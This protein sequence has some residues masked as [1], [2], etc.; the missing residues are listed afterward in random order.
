MAT[1]NCDEM[2]TITLA[3]SN[4]P[5]DCPNEWTEVYTWTATDNCENS[6]T[7]SLTVNYVDEVAP[8]FTSVPEDLFF[9]C[10]DDVPAADASMLSATDNCGD[11]VIE[12]IGDEMQGDECD[13]VISRTY[14]ATDE[15]GLFTDYV[16]TINVADTLNPTFDQAVENLT[17]ECDMVPEPAQI[18][19]SDNCDDQVSVVFNE[20]NEEGECANAYTLIRTWTATDD[21]GN[22]SVLTQIINVEDNTAPVFVD[23]PADATYNCDD[24]IPA[25]ED[26]IAVDNCSE[27][28][29][30]TSEEFIDGYTGEDGL[31]QCDLT[32]PFDVIGQPWSLWLPNN[33]GEPQYYYLTPAGGSFVELSNGR[34][35]LTGTVY[36]NNNSDKRWVIDVYFKDRLG[37][38]VWGEELNRGYKDDANVAGNNFIDWDYYI[39]NADS[40]VLTGDG[41]Y[42]GANLTLSHAPAS[43]FFGFQVGMA[44][45]NRNDADGMS[46]WFFY[47]GNWMNNDE[48]GG[49]GDFAFEKDCP[50]CDYTI[51]RI[52]TATDECGNTETAVQVITV[53]PGEDSELPGLDLQVAQKNPGVVLSA[54]PNPTALRSTINFELPYNSRV[55]L[56]VFNMD[57]KLVQALYE[58]EA[59]AEQEYMIEFNGASLESGIYL[60]KLT[61]GEGTFIDKLLI[62]R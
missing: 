51:T 5:G 19:A 38:D 32:T 49:I 21:C 8:V 28:I 7:V 10:Y 2:V 40:A 33:I 47:S 29:T 46:G 43:L 54:F 37:W 9:E 55:R 45:N 36:A 59:N 34:A 30:Y 48:V 42:A 13:A 16:Q 14:R 50:E 20:V 17:V 31:A 11:V 3:S 26:C 24:E 39:L 52:W 57:G 58:G 18:T 56:E 25:L 44:A 60:Y 35:H 41:I 53:Q 23:V 4:S 62:A 15:C 61:T 12:H 27:I 22:S 6:S 1:D